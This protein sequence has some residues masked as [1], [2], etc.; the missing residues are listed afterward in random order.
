MTAYF[1]SDKLQKFLEKH[2]FKDFS[3]TEM[4][5]HIRD[6]LGGGDTRRKIDKKAVYL[7]YLPWQRKEEKD[8]DIPDMGEETPF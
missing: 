3:S 4:M 8:L 6:K 2:R 1:K 5:A 7:W